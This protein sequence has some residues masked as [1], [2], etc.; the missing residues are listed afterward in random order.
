MYAAYLDALNKKG[1]TREEA[2]QAALVTANDPDALK[3]QQDLIVE[4]SKF[5]GTEDQRLRL[6]GQQNG[7]YRQKE[8]DLASAQENLKDVQKSI[9]ELTIFENLGILTEKEKEYLASQKK[10]E[11]E[12]KAKIGDADEISE[13]ESEIK[14]LD[15]QIKKAKGEQKKELRG[16]RRVKQAELEERKKTLVYQA[17]EAGDKLA[18]VSLSDDPELGKDVRDITKAEVH[19][20]AK[21]TADKN[22][23]EESSEKIE[24][25]TTLIDRYKKLAQETFALKQELDNNPLLSEAEK[26]I[27]EKQLEIKEKQRA[28]VE[29]EITKR[30]NELYVKK[31]GK[32]KGKYVY[33]NGEG[34]EISK[35]EAEL[36]GS[37]L[38]V[39][40]FNEQTNKDEKDRVVLEAHNK[41]VKFEQTTLQML[42]DQWKRQ[43]EIDELKEKIGEAQ[44][45]GDSEELERLS[46]LLKIKEHVHEYQNKLEKTQTQKMDGYTKE[47]YKNLEELAE[48]QHK[49]RELERKKIKNNLLIT[50]AVAF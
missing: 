48:L 5:V 7:D 14:K 18:N 10:I 6:V 46:Q 38:D 8:F 27:G 1:M 43:E 41:V 9:E 22:R 49:A 34:E 25:L 23:P 11:E 19:A 30:Q 29:A 12:L 17:K 21:S 26:K 36:L 42:T 45:K 32:D 20:L 2:L 3:V 4:N 44:E 24:H 31:E 16:E 33:V 40:K 15:E 28:D 39:D 50:M 35:E 47:G 37:Y 13:L